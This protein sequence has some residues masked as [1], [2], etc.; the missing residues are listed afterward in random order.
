MNY[1]RVAQCLGLVA[2]ATPLSVFAFRDCDVCPDMVWLPAGHFYM[3]TPKP[4]P[5]HNPDFVARDDTQPY[6]WV[7]INYR[8]AVG[9]F[10]ITFDEWQACVQGGGCQSNPKPD[11]EGWGRGRRPVINVSWLDAKEYVAWLANKTGKSYR[12]L[13]EAEWEY[14]ARA[15]TNTPFY[16]GYCI[17]SAQANFDGQDSYLNCKPNPGVYWKQTR[18]VGSYPPN[19]FGVYDMAGNVAQ[20]VDDTYM[21]NYFGAPTD[22]RAWLSGDPDVKVI[23]GASWLY[24]HGSMRTTTRRSAVEKARTFGAGFRVARTK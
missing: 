19:A 23:R 11:D 24:L 9:K 18:A 2:L 10:T 16:T 12:L 20:W 4:L 3:G 17:N 1:K 7:S 14:A 13:T 21:P 22:G 6:H 15:G 5:N 8:L